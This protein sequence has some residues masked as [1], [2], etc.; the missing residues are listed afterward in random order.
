MGLQ[1]KVVEN[2]KELMEKQGIT[3]SQLAEKLG[4]SIPLIGKMFAGDTGIHLDRLE[5]LATIFNTTPVKLLT[6]DFS[7]S[8]NVTSIEGAIAYPEGSLPG[9]AHKIA[10]KQGQI[11]RLQRDVTEASEKLQKMLGV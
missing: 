11:M 1:S 10:S 5:V 8:E 6:G 9:L 2:I 4:V 3:Q 7:Q